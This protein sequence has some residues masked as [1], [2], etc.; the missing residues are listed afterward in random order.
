MNRVLVAGGGAAG[1][2]AARQAMRGGAAVTLVEGAS[3]VGRPRSVRSLLSS[4]FADADE[5]T[6]SIADSLRDEGVE[7][8]LGERVLSLGSD[9]KVAETSK[10]S[11]L[12]FDSVVVSTG[13]VP[14]PMPLAVPPRPT[15]TAWEERATI[16]GWPSR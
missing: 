4:A 6:K 7:V 8:R 1:V 15:S 12:A 3:S 10:G 14:L 9:R 16:A 13:S 11:R 5:N 2:S